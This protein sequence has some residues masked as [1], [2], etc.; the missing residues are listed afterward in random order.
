MKKWNYIFD[1]PDG[2]KVRMI[3]DTDCKNE[4]DDQFA[5]AHH[6]MTPKFIV[7]GI[8]G[9]HFNKNPQEWGDGHT[10]E[11]SVK[12]VHKVLQLMGLDGEYE[13]QMGSEY[14]LKDENTPNP[15]DGADMIIREAMRE[16]PHPLFIACQGALTDLAIAILRE[17]KIC[18]RMTCIWIG[19]GMYPEGGFEFNLLQD[20]PAA[21]IVMKSAMPVWQIP[22]M[23][24]KQM[25]V[26]LA[27]LQ[28]YVYPCGEL[29][30]YLVEQMVAFNDK[31]AKVPQWPHGEIWGLGDSP[32]VGVLLE[33]AE[34]TDIF[35]E[36]EAPV[37]DE[38]MHYSYT[39]NGKKIRVYTDVNPRLILGDFFAK[40]KINFGH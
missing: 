11:A 16:D 34:K 33:E 24:Y 18:E 2:K 40:M 27:E 8:I 21:N 31:C 15:S 39:G 38:A 6:L 28:A 1:V 7:T 14:P 4:A 3:V 25:A 10:A 12:E 30:K 36:H 13:V 9:A 37:I 19:G 22:I 35:D 32:T 5:L 23:K 26:S 29:G 17:P 20:I